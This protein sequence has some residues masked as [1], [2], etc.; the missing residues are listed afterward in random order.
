[1]VFIFCIY[2][3]N[4]SDIPSANDSG[5]GEDDEDSVQN[6]E[7]EKKNID[8]TEDENRKPKNKK[9]DVKPTST[10]TEDENGK[11]KK[12]KRD[13][14]PKSDV[15]EDEKGTLKKKKRDVKPKSGVKEDE[16]EKLDN[17]KLDVKNTSDGKGEKR[18]DVNNDSDEDLVIKRSKTSV[19]SL[20]RSAHQ[21][22]NKNEIQNKLSK[23]KNQRSKKLSAPFILDKS[24][25]TF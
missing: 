3:S 10:L 25:V 12:K 4:P 19:V 13:V 5:A 18:H 24:D 14:K 15:T 20:R 1:M 11:P 2:S 23:L 8:V 9:R 17:K 7:K 21:Q 6:G 22:Q 16:N